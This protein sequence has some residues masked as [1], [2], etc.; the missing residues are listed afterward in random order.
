MSSLGFV[1]FKV[2]ICDFQ[3]PE[4]PRGLRNGPAAELT[5][6]PD[7][8]PHFRITR[9]RFPRNITFGNLIFFQK[10]TLVELLG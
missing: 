3:P 7:P 2:F 5:A 1:Y 4:P 6:P 10:Q 9:D 8:Y